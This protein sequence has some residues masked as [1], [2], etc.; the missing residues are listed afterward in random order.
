MYMDANDDAPFVAP[1]A[2]MVDKVEGFI[3]VY[4]E[5]KLPMLKHVVNL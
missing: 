2:V 3:P 1:P 4:L 5:K